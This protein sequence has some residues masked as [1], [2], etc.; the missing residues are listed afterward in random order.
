MQLLYMMWAVGVAA[1]QA[2][3]KTDD[4]FDEDLD[5]FDYHNFRFEKLM[6]DVWT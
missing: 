5:I 4:G 3:T 2:L 6:S 1:A